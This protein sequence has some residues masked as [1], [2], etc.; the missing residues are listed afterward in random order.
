MGLT[1]IATGTF[2]WVSQLGML[3][4]HDRLRVR[5]HAAGAH[6]RLATSSR[7]ADRRVRGA[8]ASCRSC[9]QKVLDAARRRAGCIAA[10][11]ARALRLQ[12]DR[13]RRGLGRAGVGVH[14]RGG[15]GE[16]RAD[17]EAQD[18]R[19]LPQ[20]RLRAVQGAAPHGAAARRQRATARASASR[21]CKR[22]LRLRRGDGARAAR[23]RDD[24]AARF[25]RALHRARRRR[26]RGDAS[27]SR[28]G[29]S[30]S[31]GRAA[32][33]AQHRDRHRR[34]AARAEDSRARRGASYVTSDTLWD[35]RTLPR[36]L[37][38][39]GGGP[40]GCELAQAFARFGS[41]GDADRDGA[42]APAARGRRRRGASPRA[43]RRRH[44]R[45]CRPQ[46]ARGSSERR[47]ERSWSASTTAREVAIAFDVLLVALGRARQHARAS[48]S[49]SS[50]FAYRKRHHRRRPLPPH[51][52]SRTST[53][54][55][56]SR[57]RYQFTHVA[58]HQA[59]YAAVNALFAPLLDVQGRLPRDP[60]GTFTE[61]EVARVGLDEDEA[62]GAGHRGRGHALRHRRPRPRDRRRRGHGFVKVLTAP[63]KDRILG[64]TIVGAHAG[65]LIAEFVLAMKHGLGLNKILGTIHIYPTL[66]KPTSTPP[67]PGSARMR[68]RRRC[69]GR[70][71]SSRGA[72]ASHD[73]AVHRNWRPIVM[74]APALTPSPPFVT[75][76]HG[77]QC[78]ANRPRIIKT[79][80]SCP[81]RGHAFYRH[82]MVWATLATAV[83][84]A[85]S[86]WC[87][88]ASRPAARRCRRRS[89]AATV[90]DL[91][92]GS[93]RDCLSCSRV[94]SASGVT[95]IGVDMTPSSSRS[96]RSIATGTRSATATRASNVSVRRR[97]HRGP[98]GAGIADAQRRRG[99][100][101][102]RAS[103]CRPTS[104]RVFA[105]IFRVLKPG[106]E[107]YFSDVFA[108]RR[109]PGRAATRSGAARRV[110]R[111]RALP[112]RTSAA[113]ARRWTAP[114]CARSVR[115]RSRS[116]IRRSERAGRHGRLLSRTVRAFKLDLEDRCEDYGQVATYLGTIE[117]AAH[118]F[119]LDD[120]HRFETGR[121]ML[122]CGN[123]AAMLA[124]T[125]YAPHFR[126]DRRHATTHY[127]LF[128]CGP[129]ASTPPRRRRLL[130][131]WMRAGQLI[132][133][134]SGW[135]RAI[136]CA[137]AACAAARPVAVCDV[138][139]SSPATASAAPLRAALAAHRPPPLGGPD[140]TDAG[141]ASQ[142]N[143]GAGRRATA[144]LWFLHADSRL[145]VDTL[146]ALADF[147]VR[148]EWALGY[149]DLRF[150]DDGPH[151]GAS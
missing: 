31:S 86:L 128:D 134:D 113:Y 55:A 8:R 106:G 116:T 109:I 81:A 27:S 129:A 132:R 66:T 84:D 107:L 115:T 137:R 82:A 2:Y 147:L 3:A 49:R 11:E 41:A 33:G 145:A 38:V 123:T 44:R 37:V 119:V 42:A 149:F 64:A 92:C 146:P 127:G 76:A 62:Q 14:R 5:G 138:R 22:G 18:G 77:R 110:P 51:Q 83:D 58:A 32:H 57:D 150:L 148:D 141:R 53:S 29:R 50:A 120:H 13:D 105:E 73:E 93:G 80:A 98:A 136:G 47:R 34:A 17:R 121:P 89:R 74:N 54:A 111:R 25:G 103:T 143:A 142:Q 118:A 1:P 30:R 15:E 65:E 79:A 88:S 63:G 101:Q 4:G 102:L 39:L 108:D 56:T 59:W 87:A 71:A 10:I 126:V 100:V 125:R 97:L 20:H 69:A 60:V 23:D 43:S 112:T 85:A 144:Y 70:S 151:V 67:A 139:W 6:R 124:A 9:A 104:A 114:M 7:R 135:C 117:D 40:I 78:A 36:R 131:T 48:G 99:R 94:W 133:G 90:L 19:R 68:R 52:L 12:P 91:G 72:G 61:P 21:A 46:G 35:L 140:G 45:R 95:V 28:R 26:D 24:R 96:P 75:G 130:L 16:G 122:V